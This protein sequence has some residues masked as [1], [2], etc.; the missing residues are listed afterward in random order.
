ML[1]WCIYIIIL[2]NYLLKYGLAACSGVVLCCVVSG[3]VVA[4]ELGFLLGNVGSSRWVEAKIVVGGGVLVSGLLL[5][6]ISF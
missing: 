4:N 6:G 3:C 5:C 1:T 2:C